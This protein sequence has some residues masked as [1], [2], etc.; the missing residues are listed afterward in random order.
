MNLKNTEIL[1]WERVKQYGDLKALSKITHLSMPTLSAILNGKRGTKIVNL[2][3]ISSF[4]EKVCEER[5][6]YK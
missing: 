4:L 3:K 5:K 6:Q 1:K 2:V